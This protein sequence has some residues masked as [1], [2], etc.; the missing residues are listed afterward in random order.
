MSK[1]FG[2]LLGLGVLVA[3][4]FLV[5]CG[6]Y[7][8]SS[9]GLVI[10]PSLGS[11]VV[12]SFSFNLSSGHASRIN[13]NPA[14]PG[15]PDQGGP[16]A[17][18][19][20]PSGQ[21]A[22]V[23]S[24][25]LLNPSTDQCTSSSTIATFKI[26][27]DGSVSSVGQ[28]TPNKINT[29]IPVVPVA[30]AIDSAGKY[31]FVADSATCTLSIVN[32]VPTPNVVPGAIS[33]FSI[34]PNAALT[35]VAG[36]PFTLPGSTVPPPSF[37]GVAVTRTAFPGPPAACFTQAPPSN[38]YLYAVDNA[39]NQV[40]AFSVSSGGAL[41]LLP[42]ATSIL[43]FP[44]GTRPSAV[45]VDPCN[46]FLYVTNNGSNNVSGFAIC[47]KIGQFGCV[48]DDF[49]LLSAPNSPFPVPGSEPVALAVDPFGHFLFVLGQTTAIQL[50]AHKIAQATGSL[51]QLANY[52]T[53]QQPVSIA[54]RGDGAW[55]FVTNTLSGTV[56]QF[57]L[58]PASGVLTPAGEAITTDN[59]PYGVAVK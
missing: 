32:N 1:R 33:V 36:S 47:S 43:S 49:S 15:P 39:G 46:R 21:F 23:T 45:A 58:T 11:D 53:G 16:S 9:D 38:E 19:L 54:I 52:A 35:E 18:V 12:Q 4:A 2:W 13:S 50:S 22:F 31:L 41:G 24:S 44:T 8:P 28:Q 5:A 34:G 7:S 3:I 57:G 10:V 56:S 27:S 14:I 51:T 26:N 42:G 20:D 17:I 59:F 55:L 30:L 37:V 6:S 40:V 48:A 25:H 29:T